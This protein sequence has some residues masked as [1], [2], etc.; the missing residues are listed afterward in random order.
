MSII[1]TEMTKA[2]EIDKNNEVIQRQSEEAVSIRKK[3]E[4]T[5]RN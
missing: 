2:R 5:T 4:T 1:T 3:V